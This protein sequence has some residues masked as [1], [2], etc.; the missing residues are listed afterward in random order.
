[1]VTK[2]QTNTH[3]F[4]PCDLAYLL[5]ILLA[6]ATIVAASFARLYDLERM[7]VWHDEV[8]SLLRTFGFAGHRVR[9]EVFGDHDLRVKDLLAYQRPSPELG[10]ENTLSSLMTH[11]EHSPLFYLAAWAVA[12]AFK[13]PIAGLRGTSAVLSLLLIPAMFWLAWELFKD[14]TAAWIAAALAACSPLHLLYAQEARQ[15]AIWTLLT[16]AA[17]AALLRALRQGR[18]GDW[19]VYGV[20]IALG[21]YTHLLFA[22]VLAAHGAYVLSSLR[23]WDSDA[24]A[25]LRG[26]GTAVAGGVLTFSPWIA[27]LVTRFQRVQEVTAWMERPVPLE[28]LVEAWG[29]NLVRLFADFPLSNSF[30]LLGLIPLVWVLWRFC[31]D[32]PRSARRFTCLLFLAFV[33]VVLVPDVTLGGSRSLHPRYALPGFLAVELAVAY[34]LAKGCYVPSTAGKIGSRVA[35]LLLLGLGIWSGWLILQAETWWHKNFSAANRDVAMLI[36][37]TERPLLLVSDI[38][39]GLGEVI[40]LAHDLDERVILRGESESGENRS[41]TGFSDIFLLTP[42]AEVRAGLSADYD[43]VPLLDTWQWYRAVPKL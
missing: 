17:S 25:K 26:W 43:L 21:L 1:M 13:S 22:V 35:V 33:A 4:R 2:D 8:F 41:I 5:V 14:S 3:L 16:A 9:A 12:P 29:T 19:T 6:A 23:P 36:N 42:S 32:A 37:S 27:V 20:L 31:V 38:G 24:K 28:R 11:P 40:S 30:M 15:Y 39:V 34:V 18:V 10:F 7:V